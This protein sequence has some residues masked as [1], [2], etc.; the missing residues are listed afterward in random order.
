LALSDEQRAN[1]D[2]NWLNAIARLS[3]GVSIPKA[4]AEMNVLRAALKTEGGRADDP[5]G[6]RIVQLLEGS[7]D[8]T[9]RVVSWMCLGLAGFVLLIACANIANLQIARGARRSREFAVRAALGAGRHRI[10]RQSLTESLL[11]GLAGGLAGLVVAWWGNELLG[12]SIIIGEQ[13]VEIPLNL[14]ILAYTA[15]LS[16]LAGVA[17]GVV[18]SWVK[19]GDLGATLKQGSRGTEDRSRHRLRSA[20]VVGQVGMALTLLATSALFVRG[21]R[22]FAHKDPGWK[23]EGLLA[24]YLNLPKEAYS[25]D[26]RKKAFPKRLE[27]ELRAQPGVTKAAVAGSLP[28]WPYGSST[29]LVAEGQARAPREQVP[30]FYFARVGASFFDTLGIPLVEGATFSDAVRAD[31][32]RVAVVNESVARRFWPGE[33]AIGKRLGD[34]EGDPRWREVVGVVRDVGFPATLG[35]PETAFQIYVPLEQEPSS[36]LAVVVRGPDGGDAGVLAAPLREALGAVDPDLPV[37]DLATVPEHIRTSLSSFG[38]AGRVLTGFGILGLLLA[39]LGVYGVVANV[40]VQR[41]REFGIRIAVGAQVRDVLWLVLGK[42]LRLTVVGVLVG[43]AGSFALARLMAAA[44]P[45]LQSNSGGA[46]VSMAGTLLAVAL[47]ACWLPAHR[48][49]RVDPLVALREE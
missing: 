35:A 3:P 2:N 45:S 23:T 30:L 6:L 9:G 22:Q 28:V 20:L 32:P 26:A 15:T 48:A 34:P 43:L 38:L 4:Q 33:S 8:E 31:S 12:R 21:L 7:M 18:P 16:I 17:A 1:R 46:I 41:T 40:V 42:G 27:E 19:A 29:N 11:L 49:T 47:L 37:S 25:D 5:D 24:G 39:V 36:W 14:T 13:G 10:L 44:I